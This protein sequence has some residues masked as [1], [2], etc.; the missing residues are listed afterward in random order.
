MLVLVEL[1]L[2]LLL[3]ECSDFLW[4]NLATLIFV[5]VIENPLGEGLQSVSIFAIFYLNKVSRN[6]LIET[7]GRFFIFGGDHI[8]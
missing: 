2:V 5:N 7:P 8:F 4:I 6:L 3:Q 1:T